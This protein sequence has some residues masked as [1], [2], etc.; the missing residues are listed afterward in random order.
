[1]L[2]RGHGA[3]S[4]RTEAAVYKANHG[5]G[6]C[7]GRGGN[8]LEESVPG[9]CQ[10]IAVNEVIPDKTLRILIGERVPDICSRSVSIGYG[11]SL[12]CS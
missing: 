12:V 10:R 8:R 5:V 3:R 7:E 11:M 6:V 2:L 4:S 1:M 9:G